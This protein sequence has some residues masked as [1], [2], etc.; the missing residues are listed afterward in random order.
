MAY[1][2][3]K[4]H[5]AAELVGT[6]SR[7]WG[8]STG[9][10]LVLAFALV[11]IQ[12]S[13]AEDERKWN[14]DLGIGVAFVPD[15]AGSRTASPR[16]RI[17]A[18]GGYQ[19]DD[20]GKL[21]LDSGSLTLPPEARWDFVDSRDVGVGL[22]VGYRTGRNDVNPPFTSATDGSSRLRG[23]PI[24]GGSVDAG[25]AGY[26]VAFGVPF[27]AQWRS[28]VEGS[29]GALVI[30]GAYIPLKPAPDLEFSI[31]PTVTW[32]NARQMQTFFGVSPTAADASGFA[33]Y[34]VAGGWENASIEAVADW[35][36]AG[37]W[38]LT[39]SAAYQRILGAAARSP[40]VLTP[41][42]PSVL[43]GI[44]FSF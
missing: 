20:F 5:F 30:L 3:N 38:H 4:S 36:V 15:Y 27:F 11:P 6:E 22:L 32:A 23:L 9:V 16:L 39:A 13:A 24:V 12:A 37:G 17:W 29:Q 21:A 26:L 33:P 44:V 2:K 28:A 10:V 7:D 1:R 18:D 42:Q 43:A 8:C 31:L 25:L 34:Q 19:T 35:H 41:R 40:I 14:L